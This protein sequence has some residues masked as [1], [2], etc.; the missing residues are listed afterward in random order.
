MK[1]WKEDLLAC[2]SAVHTEQALFE[3]LQAE[4][5]KIGFD[6]CAYGLRLPFPLTQP[7]TVM[8]STYPTDWQARYMA[9]NYL[10]IDPLSGMGLHRCT[11]WFG[12]A[13]FSGRLRSFGKKRIPMGSNMAGP[14]P[15]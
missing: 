6:Y 15:A 1:P 3:K 11:R 4:A 7:R 2:L 14:K 9:E 8:Y 10:A 13:P 5:R 12:A